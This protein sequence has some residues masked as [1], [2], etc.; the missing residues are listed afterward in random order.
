VVGANGIE[1]ILTL[2][3]SEEEE[4]G[5]RASAEK[6]KDTLASLQI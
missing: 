1:E 6:P 2:N 4:R 3:L 5:F